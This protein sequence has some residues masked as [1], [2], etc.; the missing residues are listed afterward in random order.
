MNEYDKLAFEQSV[1]TFLEC[2]AQVTGAYFADPGFKD[3]SNL[4]NVG[5][6]IAE[7]NE[8]GTFIIT[9]P[10]IAKMRL[11]TVAEQLLYEM[12]DPSNYIVLE[13]VVILVI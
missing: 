8:D 6:P 5:F 3:V 7:V 12:H 1:D 4:E 2:G 11:N 9:K 10:K 13:V